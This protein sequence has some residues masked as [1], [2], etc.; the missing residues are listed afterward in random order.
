MQT[1]DREIDSGSQTKIDSNPNLQKPAYNKDM[2]ELSAGYLSPLRLLA[3]IIA[4]IFIAEVI[5]MLVVYA[6]RPIPYLQLTLI[7][8]GI[9]TVLIFPLLYFLSFRPLLRYIKKNQQAE[10]KNH[11]LSSIVEQTADTV[12]VTDCDGVIE[13][14]NPAFEQV[15]GYTKEDALGKTP[16]VLKSGFHDGKFYKGLWDTILGGEVFQSEIANR[17]RNGDLFYEVKTITPLRNALG[18]ITQFVA[19]GKDITER[20]LAEEQLRKAY[21]DLELRILARTEELR[22]A[23]SE[24]EEEITERK[25]VENMLQQQTVELE[26]QAEKLR[27]Q[28]RDLVVANE[29]LIQSRLDLDRAQEVGQIGSW[30]LDVRRNI[31]AW[32]D[33]NYRIFGVPLGTPLTY[34]I[35]L[36]IIHPDDR[37][38]VD[39]QWSARQAGASY[40]IEHRLLV[41]GQ[42][43]WVRE[44]AYREFDDVGNLL[45]GFGITQ[46]ITERKQ[47]EDAL[48]QSEERY[49]LAL[50]AAALGTWRHDLAT[51][52]L[53]L[54]ERARFHSGFDT[55]AV[56]FPQVLA[57]IHPDDVARVEQEVDNVLD[58]ASSTGYYATEYR[59]I[60][61]E[62][63]IRWVSVQASAYFEG[64]GTTRRPVQV[65]GLS[66][67]VTERKQA[68][69]ALRAANEE[70]MR[71]NNLMVG[72]ELRMIE[73]KNEVNE[74]CG[75]SDQPPRYSLDFEKE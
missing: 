66:Q 55:D 13:Y 3:T 70:L 37:Q 62:G 41:D 22:I 7:D 46:D 18:D 33:E 48:R 31:L 11:L 12:V 9:M 5:A 64:Q 47:A 15:T 50:D 69:A 8:A 44:K 40:D 19:T 52:I 72:R 24:L 4:G 29:K 17:K 45:G 49:R 6:L 68:E 26:M 30:R 2:P 75:K 56:T 65:I 36:G 59:I 16:R 73:L 63:G 60:H 51:G 20:R 28:K 1:E 74:L 54:D 67:D 21:D 53:S 43:K 39:T 42:V 14:V 61:P 10:E 34:E 38:Y 27:A 35:F 57:L 25:R 71:F 23:N 32:S 58:P